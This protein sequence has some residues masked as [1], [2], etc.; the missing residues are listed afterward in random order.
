MLVFAIRRLCEDQSLNC[1]GCKIH[2]FGFWKRKLS[3]YTF[4]V[5]DVLDKAGHAFAASTA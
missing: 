2:Q 5:P 4:P 3:L 1:A